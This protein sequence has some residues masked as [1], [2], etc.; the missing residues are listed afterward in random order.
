M[1]IDHLQAFNN[2]YV[3][4]NINSISTHCLEVYSLTGVIFL[5]LCSYQGNHILSVI[6]TILFVVANVAF[7][8]PWKLYRCSITP[9]NF[10]VIW[11]MQQEIKCSYPE[12]YTSHNSKGSYAWQI[13]Q[14][15]TGIDRD[16]KSWIICRFSHQEVSLITRRQRDWRYHLP[17]Y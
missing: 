3:K 5:D 9:N 6:S 14:Y 13:L 8:M 10:L 4:T 1:G 2:H 16:E 15:S 17:I 12:K 11:P 7:Y